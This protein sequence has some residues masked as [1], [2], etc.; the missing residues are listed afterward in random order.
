[1]KVRTRQ[2]EAT[3]A[4]AG[5][6]AA[7]VMLVEIGDIVRFPQRPQA[8]QQPFSRSGSCAGA[9]AGVVTCA[10]AH[11]VVLLDLSDADFAGFS[12]AGRLA[13]EAAKPASWDERG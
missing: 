13:R 11:C 5:Q 4:G 10:N 2:K 3:L 1:M 8:G 9:L 12:L 6:F 7:L